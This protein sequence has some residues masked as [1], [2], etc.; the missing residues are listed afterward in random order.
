[1][2]S[3][4]PS[5]GAANT[6]PAGFHCTPDG[7]CDALCTPGGGQCGDGYTCTPDGNCVSNNVDAA[8]A[9]DMMC[10]A[11]NFTPKKTTPSIELLVDRS[12]SMSGTDIPPT[13]YQAEENGL[14]G[15]GGAVVTNQ[16][17]V[18]FGATL[19]AGD[20]TPCLTVTGFTAPRALNN[21]NAL[22]TLLMNNPP[23]NGSTPTADA[24]DAVT[25]DFGVNKPPPG[26]PPYILLTTD[27]EP[28]SCTNV[29]STGPSIASAKAAYAKGIGL[30]IVGLANLGNDQYL[31]DMAN[32]GTG[33]PTGQPPGCANCSPFFTADNP[34]ALT[35]SLN[36]IIAG[37][38][39]C[40]LMLT[41]NIDPN[42]ASM[43][44]VIVDGMTL[45]YGTDW[46][47]VNGNIIRLLGQACTNFKNSANPMV[48]ATFPCGSVIF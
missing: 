6:C 40:D 24:I 38:L 2:D 48:S 30:F 3:C 36:Q 19:F 15:T 41:G 4:D 13:R 9:I 45:M 35:T 16:A 29:A 28:N 12:G 32:A 11:V 1:M 8:P 39:S 44:I 33:K 23:N 25:A 7:H 20:Q 22:Q 42:Q 21:S 18:Y 5:P 17:N 31:Q 10:P 27:G 43:G 14:F 47:L 26:S 37:I 34:T 46:T